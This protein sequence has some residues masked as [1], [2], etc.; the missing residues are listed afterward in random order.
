MT[1]ITVRGSNLAC[2]AALPLALVLLAGPARAEHEHGEEGPGGESP[3]AFERTPPRLSLVDGEVSFWRPGA[4]DW[5][6]AQ[7]NVAV[8]PGDHFWAGED[9][10]LE[11]QIGAHAFVR[12]GEQTELALMTQEPDY[13][14]FRVGS[15]T[16]S[17]DL[18]RLA[19]GHT[20]ELATPQGAF[21]IE[22]TGYYRVDVEDDATKLTSRRGGL[23][24]LTP[25]QGP[26]LE[27]APSEQVV[28]AAG[29]DG[30]Q[31]ETY[32]AP[33]LDDW[34]TWNYRRTDRQLEA[35]SARYVND[36]VYGL[37]DLDQHGSW[38]RVSSYGPVW[39]PRA[40]PVGWAPYTY[41]RWL[42]DPFYGW[43][44]VDDAAWGWAPFHYG[45]WVRLHGYWAWAPGPVVVRS[46][47][48]PALV[49]FYGSPRLS[50]RISSFSP[51]LAWVA[52]G[53]GEPCVPWWGHSRWR[54]RPHWLG[55][56]GPRVVNKVVIRNQTIVH[57][58]D[59]HVYENAG[60]PGAFAAVGR[61]DFG[62]R[63]VRDARVE[64][65]PDRFERIHG[66]LPVEATRASFAS[67]AG[68]G[69]RPPERVRE[70]R[71]VATR[72]LRGAEPEKS[73][74]KLE[75]GGSPPEPLVVTAPSRG[76]RQ[77]E[78][79]PRPPFGTRAG[80]ER[81]APKAPP[82]FQ[83]ARRSAEEEPKKE[84]EL[85]GNDSPPPAPS[86]RAESREQAAPPDA[87]PTRQ[88]RAE[89]PEREVRRGSSR[90]ESPPRAEP[91]EA[92]APT[93]TRKQAKTRPS[94]AERSAEPA[95]PRLA[96]PTP[97]EELPGEPVNRVY[98]GRRERPDGGEAWQPRPERSE[99]P[100]RTRGASSGPNEGRSSG[101]ARKKADP[102]D[103]GDADERP[104]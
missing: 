82:R 89:A 72:A 100:G 32:A 71:V 34:D 36:D 22:R 9:S 57:V 52:L 5:G 90:R 79:V 49:V 21:T 53:W 27:V 85:R 12:A 37:S 46:V 45:R 18:R 83:A 96:A 99:S 50:V 55:W 3:S 15:G 64:A 98:P 54:S 77:D 14:Q 93:S 47:Y 66:E 41:G 80:A 103:L 76:A 68:K 2:F 24:T 30:P 40:V 87:R 39:I 95:E 94:R 88:T 43:T 48:A 17:L 1:T 35:L 86:D 4:E 6:P 73:I 29:P 60:V 33:E 13:L 65:R 44:W 11:I 61:K 97:P 92:P 75:R 51:S 8:A 28:V 59:I 58:K 81:P 7:V 16:A 38:R 10:N 31:I 84:R 56:G 101:R 25:A 70:R 63:H 42:Y 26:A 62:R 69:R 23:A 78:A 20:V 91:P 102:A 19:A 67:D 104:R 74:R